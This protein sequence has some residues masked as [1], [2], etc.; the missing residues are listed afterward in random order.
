MERFSDIFENINS[1]N[2]DAL[3]CFE[4]ELFW[5]EERFSHSLDLFVIVVVDLSAMVEHVANI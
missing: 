4:E 3:S 5:M 1:I 2:N